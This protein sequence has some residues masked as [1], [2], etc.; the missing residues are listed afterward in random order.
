MLKCLLTGDGPPTAVSVNMG[1][2]V[3]MMQYVIF[4]LCVVISFQNFQAFHKIA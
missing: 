4:F 1:L 3:D 2:S